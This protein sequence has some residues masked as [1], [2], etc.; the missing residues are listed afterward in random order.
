MNTTAHAAP[1]PAAAS[2]RAGCLIFVAALVAFATFDAGSKYMISRYPPTFLNLMRY[3]AVALVGALWLLR[4]WRGR[5]RGAQAG[6]PVPARAGAAGPRPTGLLVVR[7]LL[8]CAV[9]TCYMTALIWMPLSEATAI[10]FTAP[11]IM[12]ALSPWLLRERVRALQWLAVAV[13]FGGM[14]LVV[15]PGGDLPW[16]GT[17]LMAAAA[18]C[19]ALFQ[20]ATRRLAGQTPGYVQ[21]ASTTAIC[22]V[23]AALP[24]P[25]FPL[26]ATPGAGELLALLALG[27][28]SGIAQVLLIVAFQR[29]A[30]STLA[31]LNY[32]Q[33]PMAVAYS[34]F[35]FNRPPDLE[36]AAGIVLICGAGLFL[37]LNRRA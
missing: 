16:I 20:L 35:L 32:L 2:Q 24:A 12:V 37:A 8:L 21:F 23:G 28:C 9:A 7:G 6:A 1:T 14:L 36:A 19:Y 30:A 33:V 11:L 31:P 27:L 25:F 26:A 3:T 10:Y 13:G 5:A 4:A 17:A 34:T 18:I 29:V 15:R 22:W